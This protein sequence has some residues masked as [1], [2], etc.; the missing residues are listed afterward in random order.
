MLRVCVFSSSETHE[1]LY[2]PVQSI[3]QFIPGVFQV[4]R[5]VTQATRQ[6]ARTQ[7]H[8][9]PRRD[10]FHARGMRS[11]LLFK[12]NQCLF[13][14]SPSH[15][16][17]YQRF[18]PSTVC[19]ASSFLSSASSDSSVKGQSQGREGRQKRGF[20]AAKISHPDLSFFKKISYFIYLNGRGAGK[21]RNR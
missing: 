8:L 13:L 20:L 14:S 9:L 11:H 19:I 5:I 2:F 3:A 15:M 17:C 1:P 7:T 12:A 4:G 21:E 10:P 6:E 18:P 16:L